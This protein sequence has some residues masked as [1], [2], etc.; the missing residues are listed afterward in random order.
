MPNRRTSL[1]LSS[2]CGV[3]YA[4]KDTEPEELGIAASGGGALQESFLLNSSLYHHNIQGYVMNL[5]C[6]L[7]NLIQFQSAFPMQLK[8]LSLLIQIRCDSTKFLKLAMNDQH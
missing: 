2:P 1:G 6:T 3:K 7:Q 8:I 5:R 4:L